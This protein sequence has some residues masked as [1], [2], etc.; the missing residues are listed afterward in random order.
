MSYDSLMFTFDKI[1]QIDLNGEEYYHF[2]R[3]P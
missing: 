1:N 3:T 2:R